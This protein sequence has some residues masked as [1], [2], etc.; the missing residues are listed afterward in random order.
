MLDAEIIARYLKPLVP[1]IESLYQWEFDSLKAATISGATFPDAS[2]WYEK[3]LLLKSALRK[4]LSECSTPEQRIQLARYFI[5]DWGHVGTNK[6]LPAMIN[7]FTGL[8][9]K[10]ESA[11]ANIRL[12]GVSSWS[13]YISLCCEWAAIYDSRVAY[14]I[15]VIRYMSDQLDQ[16]FPMPDGRSPRLNLID[17]ETLFVVSRIR[18]GLIDADHL[19]HKHFSARIRKS[20]H[21]DE[22]KTYAR[23]IEL[24]KETTKKLALPP[25]DFFKVEMLLFAL[26]PGQVLSDLITQ[27]SRI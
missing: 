1:K 12:N 26:A 21:V 23:Y 27:Q 20:F 15:N 10:G 14:S 16:F 17:I 7:E 6:S 9:A 8:A 13:K 25:G 18:G 5:E 4:K 22:A 2:N 24:L 11:F 3:T 19:D